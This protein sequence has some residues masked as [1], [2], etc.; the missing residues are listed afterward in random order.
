MKNLEKHT[1]HNFQC[2]DC[3]FIW[4]ENCELEELSYCKR[5]GNLNF[6]QLD[7]QKEENKHD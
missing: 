2:Q 4:I 6:I 5:C 1:W 7:N 3:N